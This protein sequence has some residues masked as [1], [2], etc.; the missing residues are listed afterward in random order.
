MDGRT[1]EAR[2]AKTLNVGRPRS[3]APQRG[4]RYGVSS[5]P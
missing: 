3:P 4:D 5:N 1:R 2:T